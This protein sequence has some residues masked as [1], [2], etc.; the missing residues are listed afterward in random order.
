MTDGWQGLKEWPELI[1]ERLEGAG[2]ARIV[3]NRPDKRNALNGPLVTA[4]F[5]ALEMVRDER[6]LKVVITKSVTYS[7]CCFFNGNVVDGKSVGKL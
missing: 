5:E 6:D 2:V 1:L 3:L 7:Y 4:Y